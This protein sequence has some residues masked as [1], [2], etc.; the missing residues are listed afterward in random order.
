MATDK[1]SNLTELADLAANDLLLVTDI[2]EALDIDKSKKVKVSTVKE[3]IVGE[4]SSKISVKYV[5]IIVIPSAA[6]CSVGDN[7]AF[8]P[9]P[10]PMEGWKLTGV[11][12]W[13]SEPG[14]TGTMTVQ[15]RNKST[16]EDMLSTK[17]TFASEVESDN[18]AVEVDAKNDE[19]SEG[20]IICVDID[21]VHTTAAKGLVVE[22]KWEKP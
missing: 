20:N 19:V 2:S 16:G 3:Y 7:K 12:G 11:K 8:F 10:A 22:T 4:V 5:S 1:M 15:I 18:G 13:V 6:Y 9:I 17:L 14:V 21:S